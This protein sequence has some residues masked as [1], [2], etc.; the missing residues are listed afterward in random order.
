VNG[1]DHTV[2]LTNAINAVI[3]LRAFM[4]AMTKSGQA[5]LGNGDATGIIAQLFTTIPRMCHAFN[6]ILQDQQFSSYKTF[7]YKNHSVIVPEKTR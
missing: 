5:P 3:L 2:E 4:A 6:S 7:E 1:Q